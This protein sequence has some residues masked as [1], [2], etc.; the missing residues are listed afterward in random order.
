MKQ[1][2]QSYKTGELNLAEVPLPALKPDT[3]LVRTAASLVSVGTEKYMLELGR[4]SLLGKALARPDLL[5]QV[6][7]K[8]RAEGPLE[9]WRQARGRLD[10]PVPL[11]YSAAGVVMGVGVS[12]FAAEE[13]V[14]CA[15]SGIA[16]HA[17]LL[18]V[19]R[20]LAVK[21]PDTVGFEAASFVAM[22][23]IA[24]HAA[25]VARAAMGER[26]VVLGLGLLGQL[27]LQ[28]LNAAGCRVFGLDVVPEK[29]D[30]ALAHGAHAGATIGREDALGAVRAFSGGHGADAVLVFAATAS[31][32]PVELAA[33]M[34]RERGR[35]V[36]PGLVGLDLPRK[37]FYEKELQFTVSRAWGPGMYD[38]AYEAG[39]RDYPLPY[40]RWTAQRNMAH[41]MELLAGGRV[42]VDHLITHR[43]PIERALDAY[44]MIVEGKE[45]AI[46]VVLQYPEKANLARTIRLKEQAAP[47]RPAVAISMEG[48]DLA[49]R[50]PLRVG[51]IGAGLFARGTLLPALKGVAGIELRG[52]VTSS[53]L[54]GAHVARK[55]GLAYCTTD[56]DELLND[57]A[58]DLLM[59]LTRHGS[60]ADLVCRALAA[61]KHVFVEK[62]LAL[63]GDQLEAVIAAYWAAPGQLMV[64]FNR[65]FAPAT[66]FALQRLQNIPRPLMVSV[67]ANVGHIP[68]HAWVHDP[69]QGGGNVVGEVCHF[70]DLIQAF[71]GSTPLRVTARSAG[72]DNAGVVRQDNVTITL[73]MADG[74]LGTIV[75]SA[76]GDK[77]TPRER[78]EIFGGGAT[79]AI[80]NFRR[81][82]WSQ[83]GRRQ[84]LG[85][86]FSGVDRGHRAEMAALVGALRTGA[87]FPVP[88]ESVVATT[89][90]TFAALE[91]LR[92]GR[93]VEVEQQ[94]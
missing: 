17:E 45:P 26:V 38:P 74:S 55:Y 76:L 27:A 77:A 5:R 47:A 81:A 16:S 24:V 91:S 12:G 86:W 71:S 25:R 87:P 35:V 67:R 58:I 83:A 40:V 56:V 30:V 31:N 60:H 61:G 15:G 68:P 9:A 72:G 18:R 7:A 33:E 59:V 11:G 43:F 66:A 29:V 69:Q 42:A 41:F 20:T 2:T 70:V 78:V 85:H 39:E 57:P 34:A 63:N 3:L 50:D 92:S 88:F 84:R 48:K 93:P 46:G 75:Y 8:A 19:P 54:S 65:R 14:A 82:T 94:L 90:A 1:V 13:R 10:T 79:C 53:G 51:L 73:E 89:R 80:E 62:P 44:R 64:G 6:L 49:P 36:V 23:G 4:K 32:Q 28:I 22:G 37:L 52:V 21:I